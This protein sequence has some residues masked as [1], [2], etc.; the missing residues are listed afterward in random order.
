ML[1]VPRPLS[2]QGRASGARP[3]AGAGECAGTRGAPHRG[4]GD[5]AAGL[6]AHGAHEYT[7]KA[8]EHLPTLTRLD[9]RTDTSLMCMGMY[10]AC[11]LGILLCS[12]IPEG[13]ASCLPL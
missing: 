8:S 13:H 12:T 4:L 2:G 1:A 3:C 5:R 11:P 7:Q 6:E 10:Y 9:D